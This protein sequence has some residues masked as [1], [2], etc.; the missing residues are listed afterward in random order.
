MIVYS[1]QSW[2][3]DIF[4]IENNNIYLFYVDETDLNSRTTDEFLLQFLRARKY[5]VNKSF[6]LLKKYMNF[7]R[8]NVSIFT[9]MDYDRIER[10]ITNRTIRFLPYRDAE[11]CAVIAVHLGMKKWN[12]RNIRNWS[13]CCWRYMNA[14]FQVWYTSVFSI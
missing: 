14:L 13:L 11:G 2:R 3:V 6:S 10:L 1:T 5:N 9:G 8:K 7:K 4:H 12:M